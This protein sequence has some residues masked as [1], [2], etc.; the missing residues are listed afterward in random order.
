ME[1]SATTSRSRTAAA[2]P[3]ILLGSCT[4]CA[5]A[6]RVVDHLSDQHFATGSRVGE[7][8]S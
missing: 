4:S 2:E 6:Q 7:G 3:Q 1:M 8:T 5:D